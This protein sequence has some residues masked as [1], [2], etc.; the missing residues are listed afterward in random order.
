[1]VTDEILL[2]IQGAIAAA[3]A[4]DRPLKVAELAREL[5]VGLSTLR[6]YV[7]KNELTTVARNRLARIA[8]KSTSHKVT[9]RDDVVLAL[10][11]EVN[12]GR[13]FIGAEFARRHDVT[14]AGL[15][16]YVDIVCPETHKAELTPWG[17]SRVAEIKGEASRTNVR[18]TTDY[19]P[20]LKAEVDS[21][22]LNAKAFADRY[23]LLADSVLF[24]AKKLQRNAPLR[25][26]TRPGD[27]RALRDERARG[28][29]FD[30]KEWAQRLGLTVRTARAYVTRQGELTAKGLKRLNSEASAVAESSRSRT[31]L[32]AAD[33][34]N[35]V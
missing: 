25:K 31:D 9:V 14:W 27:L 21:G 6:W 32:G 35:R 12:S 4:A 11:A 15:R 22:Q 16:R 17:K 7:F 28:G 8:E 29:P 18:L 23:G 30:L 26:M 1:M 20:A 34:P 5:R 2:R 10:E 19:W 3:H 33:A 13:P 24:D